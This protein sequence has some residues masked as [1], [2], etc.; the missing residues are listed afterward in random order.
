MWGRCGES[1]FSNGSDRCLKLHPDPGSTFPSSRFY[2]HHNRYSAC[3]P[4]P[5]ALLRPPPLS[6]PQIDLALPVI[7]SLRADSGLEVRTPH[8]FKLRF[9]RM[10]LDTY[11]Q[12][13]QLL[14]SL[15][16]PDSISM[17]GQTL[18]LTPLK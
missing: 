14:V 8:S 13:P 10:G 5:T 12:T 15:D 18:D 11:V 16:L 2:C 17:L 4:H 6:S 3:L 9:H 1:G 7:L